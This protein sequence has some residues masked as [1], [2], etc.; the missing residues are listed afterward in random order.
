MTIWRVFPWSNP[1]SNQGHSRMCKHF[2]QHLVLVEGQRNSL[3][4]T[5]ETPDDLTDQGTH[6]QATHVLFRSSPDYCLRTHCLSKV[7]RPDDVQIEA[8]KN[9]AAPTQL[10]KFVPFLG[11]QIIVRATSLSTALSLPHSWTLTK[12][13]AK[14]CW[15][16]EQQ[17]SIK[18]LKKAMTC[19]PV[20]AQCSLE[21][22]TRVVVDASPWAVCVVLLQEQP[23]HTH[24][25]VAYGSC[26]S[27]DTERKYCQIEKKG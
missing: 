9:A 1:R 24:Q 22:K 6:P 25:P 20:L 7:I 4:T 16:E 26:S 5:R 27:T 18:A 2:R 23:D 12:V 11:L 8:V 13:N 3:C 14:F 15:G 17:K 21:A 19:Q 10:Q